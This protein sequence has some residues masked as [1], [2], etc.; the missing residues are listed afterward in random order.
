[1]SCNSNK[2][3]VET[4]K[5][6]NLC[7]KTYFSMQKLIIFFRSV[8]LLVFLAAILYVYALLPEQVLIYQNDATNHYIL[9]SNFFFSA[10]GVFFVMNVIIYAAIFFLKRTYQDHYYMMII[11][12]LNG[13]AGVLNIFLSMIMVIVLAINTSTGLS[14]SFLV[15]VAFLLVVLWL[16]LLPYFFKKAK[17]VG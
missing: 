8:S 13:F 11:T 3:H 7:H 4:T 2:I 16:G 10:I 5:H 6:V 17:Q 15:I 9:R 14:I 12:W 1:M